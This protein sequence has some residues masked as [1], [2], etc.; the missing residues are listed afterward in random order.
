[1]T[2]FSKCPPKYEMKTFIS[3]NQVFFR[4]YECFACIDICAL[5]ACLVLVRKGTMSPGTGLTDGYEQPYSCWEPNL[6]P[7]QEQQKLQIKM[8]F[9]T[10]VH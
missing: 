3:L 5:N 6:S 8:S 2:L 7:L 9:N 4:L 1:M 10:K